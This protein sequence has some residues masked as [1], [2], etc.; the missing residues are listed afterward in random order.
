MSSFL[1][2]GFMYACNL[3]WNP[4]FHFHWSSR[5]WSVHCHFADFFLQH[6]FSHVVGVL[7]LVLGF[8]LDQ[9]CI[10]V[11]HRETARLVF[12]GSWPNLSTRDRKPSNYQPGSGPSGFPPL[13]ISPPQGVAYAST[14]F[15]EIVQRLLVTVDWFL[16]PDFTNTA[17]L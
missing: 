11:N 17:L 7:K 15:I 14:G 4:T 16:P 13:D 3:Q 9:G 2:W 5:Q 6:L 12:H 1:A 10:W 8:P